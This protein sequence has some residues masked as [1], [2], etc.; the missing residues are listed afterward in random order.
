MRDNYTEKNIILFV[1]AAKAT[2]ATAWM[3]MPANPTRIITSTVQISGNKTRIV[4]VLCKTRSDIP[5]EKI[6]D[7]MR[8][9]K[10]SRYLHRFIL[11]MSFFQMS[12]EPV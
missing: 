8:I 12:P 2:F 3:A 6:F 5:K 1:L 9:M 11:V 10:T 7:V 4:T